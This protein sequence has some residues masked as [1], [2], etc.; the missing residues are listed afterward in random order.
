MA[1]DCLNITIAGGGNPVLG[2]RTVY[3]DPT[4]TNADI[5][6]ALGLAGGAHNSTPEITTIQTDVT[7]MTA[8]TGDVHIVWNTATCTTKNQMR[9][10]LRLAIAAVDAVTTLTG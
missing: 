9:N 1:T 4:Q 2:S 8:V 10:A 3:A 5:T 7:A 6:T